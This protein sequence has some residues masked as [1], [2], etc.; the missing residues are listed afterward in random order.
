[1]KLIKLST[2]VIATALFANQVM[3]AEHVN[4]STG[5][6]L[7]SISASSYN[8]LD[9]AVAKVEAKADALG[10]SSYRIISTNENKNGHT[11]IIAVAYK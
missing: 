4:T 11:H 1:M 8:G 2:L 10:A 7:G 5:E 9:G 3:A 6:S